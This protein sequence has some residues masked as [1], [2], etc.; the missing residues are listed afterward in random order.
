MKYSVCCLC[1]IV[2][3]LIYFYDKAMKNCTGEEEMMNNASASI[4][5]ALLSRLLNVKHINQLQGY[6]ESGGFHIPSAMFD[7][8]HRLRALAA[9]YTALTNSIVHWP[10]SQKTPCGEHA[11]AAKFVILQPGSSVKISVAMYENA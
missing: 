5:V 11:L 8:G 2:D 4:S 6:S 10:D 1:K 9:E 3:A 7:F